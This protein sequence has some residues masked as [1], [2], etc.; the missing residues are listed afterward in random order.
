MEP[1]AQGTFAEAGALEPAAMRAAEA[2]LAPYLFDA[3]ATLVFV[4]GRFAPHLSPA[5]DLGP[6]VIAT[7]LA[8]V[9]ARDTRSRSSPTSAATRASSRRASWP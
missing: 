8:E 2:R 7:S 5:A 4:D 9:L 1:I 6:G 3:A